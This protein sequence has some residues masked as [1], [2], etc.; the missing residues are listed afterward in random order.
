M[1]LCFS[2]VDLIKMG[3]LKMEHMVSLQRDGILH[4]R[5]WEPAS[6]LFGHLWIS[7]IDIDY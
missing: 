1:S 2:S 6:I 3:L 7:D 5:F 4:W